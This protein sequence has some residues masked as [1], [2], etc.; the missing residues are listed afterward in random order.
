MGVVAADL[1]E[2]NNRTELGTVVCV[3]FQTQFT[4]QIPPDGDKVVA[5]QVHHS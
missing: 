2:A 5:Y 1:A 3:A 4:A